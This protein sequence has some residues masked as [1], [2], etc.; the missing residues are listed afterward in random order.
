MGMIEIVLALLLAVAGVAALAR[1]VPV[2]L[3]L[4]QIGAGVL[5]SLL[6]DFA[7]V[8]IEP[9]P[10]FLL[11]IPP[12]L[13][14]DAWQI[15]K[16]DLVAV[17]RPVLMLAFGL[18]LATVVAVGY[19]MHALIPAL[20]LA[21][22]FALG[23]IVSPTDAVA[24]SAMI[25]KLALPRRVSMILAG[26]SLIND[27]SGLVALKFAIAAALTAGAFSLGAA[28]RDLVLIAA[29]GFATG[30]LV[31][32]FVGL[33][34]GVLRR[35]SVDDP[36]THTMLSLLTPFAAYLAGDAI[37]ASGVLAVV[38]A[39]L[40]AGVYDARHMS[41]R[42]RQH[43]YQVWAMV[44]YAFNGLAFVLLGLS[45][46][47]AL[48]TL[49]AIESHSALALY[50]IVLW[51]V[52]TAV[53]IA[54][55]YPAAWLPYLLSRKVR[56]AEPRPGAAYVL[57]IGW[58]GLRGA[59]TM[60]A[61][62]ALPAAALSGTE[63]P[64]RALL[65]FLA[66]TTIL[67]T[68]CINGL[69]LPWLMRMLHVHGDGRA[70]R[71][72]RAAEIAVA[73]AGARVIREHIARSPEPLRDDYLRAMLAQYESRLA[74]LTAAPASREP[75]ERAA[76]RG[77]ALMFEAIRAERDALARM[78]ASGEVN[79][80][81]ARDVETRI[82]HAELLLGDATGDTLIVPLAPAARETAS[83]TDAPTAP[84]ARRSPR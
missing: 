49:I 83:A 71:E 51:L 6:P 4:L 76:R 45:L 32:V 61:A 37:G 69:A 52:I 20:P 31:G 3:P 11:F 5:L 14:G 29:G 50:A 17:R 43:A 75:H 63:F 67:L 54:W 21:A 22:A 79:D 36:S 26:E 2:P 48:S 64:G 84:R 7:N 60:A 8:H 66:A 70:E 57:V 25:G 47:P 23:A 39:G 1:V 24:T 13:F 74:R 10:F 30:L 73:E 28:A 38:G 77:R 9:G 34:R 44:L 41:V 78:R 53:R 12:L 27:A 65:I 56:D 58:A 80:D 16:R 35:A 82:D 81:V 19:V 33:V 59:V 72:R 68:L 18:V 42:T 40:Y 15:P 55:V 46:R 62:L